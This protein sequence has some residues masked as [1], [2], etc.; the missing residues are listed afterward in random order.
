MKKKRSIKENIVLVGKRSWYW[1]SAVRCIVPLPIPF[2]DQLTVFLSEVDTP[3]AQKP[4]LQQL[5]SYVR[6]VLAAGALKKLRTLSAIRSVAAIFKIPEESGNHDVFHGLRVLATVWVITI[7][8]HLYQDQLLFG[9][10]AC[11]YS[12]AAKI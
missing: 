9:K 6:V 8:T 1:C 3:K 4:L 12:P 10:Y 11:S 5:C 2:A 7:H